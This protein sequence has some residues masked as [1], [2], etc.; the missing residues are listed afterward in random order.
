V[1]DQ[2]AAILPGIRAALE[3]LAAAAVVT[4]DLSLAVQVHQ[5]KVILAEQVQ[6][7]D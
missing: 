3:D 5:D 4:Q 6:D 7:Q 2:V 1:A